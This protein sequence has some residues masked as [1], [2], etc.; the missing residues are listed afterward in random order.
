MTI[1]LEIGKAEKLTANDLEGIND[2]QGLINLYRGVMEFSAKLNNYIHKQELT[3][4]QKNELQV[5]Y[6]NG[7]YNL[8]AYQ[9]DI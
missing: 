9:E 7:I 8:E 2:V 5:M 6:H 3:Y 1:D 4:E